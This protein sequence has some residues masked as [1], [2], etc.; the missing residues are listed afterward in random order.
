MTQIK[1]IDDILNN[2]DFDYI[3]VPDLIRESQTKTEDQRLVDSFLEINQFIRQN[4]HEPS[5]LSKD[6]N[7]RKL[8]VRLENFKQSQQKTE[9]LKDYDEFKLLPEFGTNNKALDNSIS[10]EKEE[11]LDI[12][13]IQ[14]IPVKNRQ[15][16]D[17]VARR[18]PCKDFD[19]FEPLFKD[20][21][22][23]LKNGKYKLINL[24]SYNNNSIK[25]NN[26]FVLNGLLVYLS[27]LKNENIDEKHRWDGRTR[28]IFENG[29]ESSMK[30][31]TF[32]K[33]LSKN[34]KVVVP[35]IQT[36]IISSE[37]ISTGYIYVLKSLSTNPE[38]SSIQNLYKIGYSSTTVEDR[39]KNAKTDP[40][41]LNSEVK[42]VATF[43]TIDLNPQKLEH[44]LHRFFADCCLN[45]LIDDGKGGKLKPREWFIIPIKVI[46]ETIELIINGNITN[47]RYDSQ[48]EKLVLL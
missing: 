35:N 22:Q 32:G 46:I 4:G 6:I 26:F 33:T 29:T 24:P 14:N 11:D 31:R 41:Y 30:I 10:S 39:I 36:E 43:K 38:I 19:R 3:L 34:G 2:S 48:S 27:E 23:K 28:L 1:S 13:K 20:C 25:I 44:L 42:V 15:E 7:E 37:N 40:T 45:V 12:F 18:K 17:F 16:T 21:H 8:Q 9:Y 5:L 47:Y